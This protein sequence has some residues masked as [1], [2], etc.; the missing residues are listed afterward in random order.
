MALVTSLGFFVTSNIFYNIVRPLM[1]FVLL[2]VVLIFTN[3]EFGKTNRHKQVS[4]TI[5]LLGSV[6]YVALL[7]L[8]ALITSLGRNPMTFNL[9]LVW[10]YLP[11]VAIGEIIRFQLVQN[12]PKKYNKIMLWAITL[13]FTFTMINVNS[14]AFTGEFIFSQLLPILA[15]NFFL[16]YVCQGGSFIGLLS[17]R[18]AYSLIPVL[19]P[20]LPNITALLM[21]ILTYSAVVVM[22]ALYNRFAREQDNRIRLGRRSRAW[23]YAT[24]V[25]AFIVVMSLGLFPNT[26]VAVASNSM[27]GQFSRGDMVMMRSLTTEQAAEN[28][29]VGDII[30]FKSGNIH[31]IHRIIEIQ[32]DHNGEVQ[33]I[34]KGDNN[35]K[36]DD[37]PVSPDRVVGV[38]RFTIRYL[39]FPSVLLMEL[40]SR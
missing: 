3:L 5:L 2:A 37:N 40:M 1:Y 28:L 16:T 32:N 6:I 13:V 29:K 34:T 24:P 25:I 12:T 31:I 9:E 14:V 36:A 7:F 18:A 4:L 19:M 11:F 27:K 26:F 38:A 21:A 39:G 33:F 23:L 10:Q 8:A 22:L 15:V 17:F 35:E 30:Q 20:V